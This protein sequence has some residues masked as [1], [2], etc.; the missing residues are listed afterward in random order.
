MKII[1]V[2][3]DYPDEK[4]AKNIGDILLK[5]KLI[6]CYNLFPIKSGYFWQGKK[7]EGEEFVGIFK[8]TKENWSKLKRR[9]KEIHPY[10]IPCILKFEVEANREYYQWVKKSVR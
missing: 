10:E 1:F 5:E 3:T 4:T 9:I 6:A 2:Y 8:T 7:E